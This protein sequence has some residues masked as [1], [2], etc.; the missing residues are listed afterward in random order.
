MNYQNHYHIPILGVLCDGLNFYFFEF[1]REVNGTRPKF[2]LG[3]FSDGVDVVSI[4]D[5]TQKSAGRHYDC[6]KAVREVRHSCEALYFVFLKGYK[7]G[8]DAFR[9]RS[10]EKAK[11]EGR[12]RDSTPGWHNAMVMAGKAIDEAV[13][14]WEKHDKG[15]CEDAASSAERALQF[16]VES[17]L[18]FQCIPVN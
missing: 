7:S 6:Q 5:H 17:L 18:S 1:T 16:L 3:E 10:I 2:S 8:L 11:Q 12:E 13:L 14:A 9:R 15:E 4:P